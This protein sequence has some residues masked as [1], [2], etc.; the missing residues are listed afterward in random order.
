MDAIECSCS[1]ELNG[2]MQSKNA[3]KVFY[4]LQI[5][6]LRFVSDETKNPT[7]AKSLQL[8]AWKKAYGDQSLA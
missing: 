2:Q 6:R 3:A 7:V 8:E 1:A 5:N 4:L